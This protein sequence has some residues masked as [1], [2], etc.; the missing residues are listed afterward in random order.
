MIQQDKSQEIDLRAWVTRL[1]KNWYWFVASCSVFIMVGLYVYLS[2]PNEFEVKAE[3]MLRDEDNGGAFMQAEMLSLMGM[4]GLKLVDDEIAILT[5]RDIVSNVISDLNLQFDYRK[6]DFLKWVGQYPKT[7]LS[8]VCPPIFIDTLTRTVTIELKA[9]KDDYLVKVKYSD[10]QCS[11]HIV[12][13]LSEAI[14]TCAGFFSFDILRPDK[15]EPGDRY[16]IKIYPMTTAVNR[17]KNDVQVSAAKKDSKVIQI[18]SV[19]DIPSRAKDYISR[20]VELYNYDAIVDKNMM[21]NNTAEFINERLRMIEEELIQAEERAVQYQAKYGILNPEVEAEIFL[22]ENMEYRKQLAEIETQL[23]WISFLCD[24]MKEEA[25][26]NYLL[27]TTFTS[28]SAKHSKLEPTIIPSSVAGTDMALMAAIE[29]YNSLMLKRMRLERTLKAENPMRDQMDEQL[30]V[31]RANIIGSVENLQKAL[32]I[33]KQDLEKQFELASKKRSDMPDLVRNYEKML[34]EKEFI[35]KMYLFICQQREENAMLLAAAVVPAKVVTKPQ[36][37]FNLVRPHLKVILLVCLILGLIFPVGVMIVYDILNNRISHEAKD[38]EKRLKIPFAGVLVKNHHG[39]H[40]AVREGENSVSAELFRTL[41]TNLSFMQ[42][43]ATS[44]PILLVTSSINGEGKSYVA[45][46]LAISMTILGKKVAL[47]GLDI[48][49]PMLANYLDLPTNGCLTSY[50]S[51]SAYTMEDII[52]STNIAHL[53]VIPAGIIPPNP[54]ELLQSNRLDELFVE[55]RKRYDYIVVDSAP[56]A[57][58]SDTFLL[59]RVVDMTVYVT[60]AN[61][62]TF[63]LVDFLNQTHEQQRLPKMVAVLN[64]VDAKKIGYGYGYGYGQDVKSGKR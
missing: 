20:L 42:P 25:N 24:F 15:I 30:I 45:T 41:R 64:G 22:T 6:K 1:I 5:S 36:T 8:I 40:I 52:V 61:Y 53:D 23:N 18:S 44:C 62:T 28:P 7:D 2:T 33:S 59:N 51:D 60:R 56:V 38:L 9:R 46:N 48:R 4:G 43:S 13:N 54:S 12:S 31:L 35:E 39:E 57:M 3:I 27:P 49:K 11:K 29:E 55:L 47:V 19:T 50:L 17:Y 58:V 10:N 21:A 63:E 16:R 34:R 37:D 14:E 32:L 26:K